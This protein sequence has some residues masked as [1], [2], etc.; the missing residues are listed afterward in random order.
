MYKKQHGNGKAGIQ[1]FIF[2]AFGAISG[3][4]LVYL[5]KSNRIKISSTK[6]KDIL[7]SNIGMAVLCSV[8]L[9][10][11]SCAA[12]VFLLALGDNVNS[13]DS[14]LMQMIGNAILFCG[15]LYL[16]FVFR[17]LLL[18]VIGV[19][20]RYKGVLISLVIFIVTTVYLVVTRT[21]ELSKIINDPAIYCIELGRA[22]LHQMYW[23]ISQIANYP[24]GTLSNLLNIIYSSGGDQ[25]YI[26]SNWPTISIFLAFFSCSALVWGALFGGKSS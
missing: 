24:A 20:S 6:V 13:F 7:F 23:A 21:F 8:A 10:G 3:L 15:E 17:D 4:V 25:F 9:V 14:F 5:I 12:W 22:S 18:K 11:T 19:D 2:A 16:V 1:F 26:A